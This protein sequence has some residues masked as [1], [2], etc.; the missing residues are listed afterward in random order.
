MSALNAYLKVAKIAE[1]S[2]VPYLE[3]V[4]KVAVVIFEL[5]EV[6]VIDLDH[7]GVV[8]YSA[9]YSKEERTRRMPKSSV[10]ASQ[11]QSSL[12]IPSF[13]CKE[14]GE[15]PILWGFAGKWKG[16]LTFSSAIL[17]EQL[18]NGL[19]TGISKAWRKS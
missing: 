17:P 3:N 13:V 14:S 6:C 2:S 11:T 12:S 15:L 16:G 7:M 10:R 5:L 18:F 1:A 9:F 4:A 19:F 8:A